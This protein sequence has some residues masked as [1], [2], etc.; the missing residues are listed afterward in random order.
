[1][2]IL[3][4]VLFSV[5]FALAKND[6]DYFIT[7]EG[8][9][10]DGFSKDIHSYVIEFEY[11]KKSFVIEAEVDGN[12]YA[13]GDLGRNRIS[14]GHNEFTIDIIS[15]EIKQQYTFHVLREFPPGFKATDKRIE[16][17]DNFN[18]DSRVEIVFDE[19]KADFDTYNLI[20]VDED[21]NVRLDYDGKYHIKIDAKDF[22]DRAFEILLMQ[23]DQYITGDK[24]SLKKYY[25]LKTNLI[26]VSILLTIS[27]ILLTIY[28]VCQKRKN[29]TKI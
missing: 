21:V 12:G 28:A 11:D 6:V 17:F 2:I 25:R 15:N 8:K 20:S 19:Y 10:V 1:M 4:Y 27:C 9:E 16:D 7:V 29:Q 24:Q 18:H 3:F 23:K 14:Y 26:I 22:N 13:I 5:T